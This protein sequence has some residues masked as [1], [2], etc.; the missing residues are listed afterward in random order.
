MKREYLG[1]FPTAEEAGN[2]WL[3]R[4]REHAILL[5]S[6]QSDVRIADA[7]INRFK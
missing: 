6:M 1:V 2:K 3:D 7:L 5:A 4:K